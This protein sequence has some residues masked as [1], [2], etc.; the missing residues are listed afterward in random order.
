[1][2]DDVADN[3]ERSEEQLLHDLAVAND[4][5]ERPEIDGETGSG[6]KANPSTGDGLPDEPLPS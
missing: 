1:V 6:A 5:G 3:Q 2:E 4:C